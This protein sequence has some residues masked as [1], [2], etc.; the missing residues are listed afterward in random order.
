MR[1]L[2]NGSGVYLILPANK[3]AVKQSIKG[4]VEQALQVAFSQANEQLK[5]A[6]KIG[7]TKVG[8]IAADIYKNADT[9]T[10]LYIG[11]TPGFRLPIKT[12]I[13]NEGGSRTVT[14]SAIRL[15]PVIADARF[16]LPAGLQIMDDGG[17][18]LK[19][20]APR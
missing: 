1:Y 7:E 8:A 11:K 2:A 19:A 20:A 15:N 16:A 10:T 9:G 3:T 17:V 4:G 12:L 14:V 13:T 6:K 18:P 5:T